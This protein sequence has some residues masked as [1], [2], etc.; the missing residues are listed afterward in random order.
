MFS[1]F[2][3][4]FFFRGQKKQAKKILSSI[5]KKHPKNRAKKIKKGRK[6]MNFR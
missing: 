2:T 5:F 6:M 3:G 4:D 1:N